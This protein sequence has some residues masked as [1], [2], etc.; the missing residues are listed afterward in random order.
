MAPLQLSVA[1]R[2][3]IVGC[4]PLFAKEGPDNGLSGPRARKSAAAM[5]S[6]VES[7]DERETARCC[8]K[9]KNYTAETW[10]SALSAPRSAVGSASDN[11]FF[12][13]FF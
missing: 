7:D 5:T 11:P 12:Q 10:R 9:K 4:T 6:V 13:I 1:A 3:H 2:G 8:K